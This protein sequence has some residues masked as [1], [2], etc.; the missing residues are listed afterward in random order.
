MSGILE[1]GGWVL[2]RISGGIGG[3]SGLDLKVERVVCVA[4]CLVDLGDELGVILGVFDRLEWSGMKRRK[5]SFL[6]EEEEWNWVLSG[7]LLLS[8]KAQGRGRSSWQSEGVLLIPSY[9]FL[10][11]FICRCPAAINGLERRW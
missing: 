3:D 9:R 6:A 1:E 2:R 10:L 8:G 11:L 7:P 4:G 5:T